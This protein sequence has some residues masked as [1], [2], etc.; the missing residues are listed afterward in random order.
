M[1]VN[2]ATNGA[3]IVT[4]RIEGRQLMSQKSGVVMVRSASGVIMRPSPKVNPNHEIISEESNG[5]NNMN[6]AVI[7]QSGGS[8]TINNAPKKRFRFEEEGSSQVTEVMRIDE[9]TAT[10]GHS[11]N[12]VHMLTNP[13]FTANIVMAAT[14]VDNDAAGVIFNLLQRLNSADSVEM[15]TILWSIW[16]Q[17]NNKLWK[18]SLFSLIAHFPI[19]NLVIV[20]LISMFVWGTQMLQPSTKGEDI[21][22]S[23]SP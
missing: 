13:L 5:N 12:D 6:V 17:R 11:E 21:I 2:N 4:N 1:L 14:N 22:K 10:E 20:L 19:S 16:K 9:V 7:V 8:D 18:V 3:L 15:A 23:T